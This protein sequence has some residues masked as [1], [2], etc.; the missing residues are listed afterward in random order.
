MQRAHRPDTDAMV[1]DV[2]RA[3]LCGRTKRSLYIWLPPEDPMSKKGCLGKMEKA[4]H[5][6][7]DA[8]QVWQSEVR[9]TMS[10][11]E[12]QGCRTQPGIYNCTERELY[13][14]SHVGDFLALG[15]LWTYNGFRRSCPRSTR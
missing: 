4:M 10:G 7:R 2:K 5:G 13:V 1:L 3:F 12:L 8:P 11:L 14:V 15:V 9:E 6:T